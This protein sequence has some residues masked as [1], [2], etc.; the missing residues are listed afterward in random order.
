MR[1]QA[2]IGSDRTKFP[3]FLSL[4]LCVAWLRLIRLFILGT[5]DEL[6]I[7]TMTADVNAVK[8]AL[9]LGVDFNVYIHSPCSLTGNK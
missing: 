5:G 7:V 8:S 2:C 6:G 9:A 1:I 4:F 3:L